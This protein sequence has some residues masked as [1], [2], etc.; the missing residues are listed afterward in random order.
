MSDAQWPGRY[1]ARI[2]LLLLSLLQI[3]DHT[4]DT[5]NRQPLHKRHFRSQKIH[6]HIIMELIKLFSTYKKRIPSHKEHNG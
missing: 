1:S 4:T 3:N 2:I 6:F 5:S